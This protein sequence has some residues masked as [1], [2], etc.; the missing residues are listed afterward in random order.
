VSMLTERS[1]ESWPSCAFGPQY[2][3]QHSCVMMDKSSIVRQHLAFFFFFF[4]VFFNEL[5]NTQEIASVVQ[6]IH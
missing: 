1:L 6:I 2:L 4:C 5:C 3:K